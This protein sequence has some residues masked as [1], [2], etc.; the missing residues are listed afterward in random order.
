MKYNKCTEDI[1]SEAINLIN[2]KGYSQKAA[3]KKLN[4]Y[5]KTLLNH[6]LKH[7][8]KTIGV[9][10]KKKIDSKYFNKI[11]IESKAYWLGFLTADGYLSSKGT[12]ELTLAEKDFEHIKLFKWMY[13]D[14]TIYL[15]RKY[16]RFAVSGQIAWRSEM[17]RVELN[18]ETGV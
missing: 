3:A 2:N 16:N 10:G 4:V 8:E 17:I 1:V 5:Y 6:L 14:V 15:E 7:P 13:A 12:L 9:K 18:G 11:D